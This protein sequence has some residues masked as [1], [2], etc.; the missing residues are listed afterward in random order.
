MSAKDIVRAWKNE[1]YFNTLSASEAA[2]IPANPA[3]DI[4]L[5][6]YSG[7]LFPSPHCSIVIECSASNCGA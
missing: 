5:H 6:S 3:G 7:R 4:E 1:E 2:A